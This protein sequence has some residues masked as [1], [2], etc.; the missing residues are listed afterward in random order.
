M[1]TNEV[2][3]AKN[4]NKLFACLG[5]TVACLAGISQSAHAAVAGYVQFVSGDVQITNAAGQ[6]RAAQK[7][8]A[9]SE[10]DTLASAPSSSA[11]IKMQDG[12]L[13]AVR[14]DTKLKFDQFVFAGKQDGNE[15]SFFSLFKGGFRAITGLIGQVNKQ[16]YKITTPAAT[17]GIRGTDHESFVVTPGSPLAQVAPVGAYSKVNVGETYMATEKGT[18]FVQPNQ[19]GFAGGMNQMPQLQPLNTNIFTVAAAPTVEAKVEK[20]EEKKEEAPVRESAVVDA[21]PP[22]A[23]TI[24]AATTPVMAAGATDMAIFVPV[25]E[26]VLPIVLA[27][28]G[29][30]VNLTT[31]TIVTTTGGIPVAITGNNPAYAAQNGYGFEALGVDALGS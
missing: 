18:I 7:G 11:Q 3:F 9:I 8:D 1:K 26:P 10:G 22:A 12:G 19:M 31:Q 27:V 23:G 5:V 16:N 6:S 30:T 14:P 17:I 20:K 29:Q 13:V 25:M 2:S 28:D 4:I 24:P 15:K 21:T